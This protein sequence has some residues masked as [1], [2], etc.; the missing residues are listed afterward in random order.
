MTPADDGPPDAARDSG[1]GD[2]VAETAPRPKS[3]LFCPHCGH[4]SRADGDWLT[5]DDLAERSRELSCP[6]CATRLTGR[7]LPQ[8]SLGTRSPTVTAA[9]RENWGL[10]TT[11]WLSSLTAWTAWATEAEGSASLGAATTY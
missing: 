11:L 2:S 6:V 10:W 4:E 5:A 9:M 1:A 8:D 3:V 7:P